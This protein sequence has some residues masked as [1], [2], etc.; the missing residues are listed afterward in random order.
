M[1]AHLT[2]VLPEY[3]KRRDALEAGL[4][5]HLPRTMRWRQPDHGVLLWLPLPFPLS[6]EAVFEEA[7]RRG[8]LVSPST[9][10]A[11]DPRAQNGVRLTFCAEPPERLAE[12]AKR[13]GKAMSQLVA[14]YAPGG[15]ITTLEVV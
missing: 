8:V 1:R 9:L 12:G 3:R 7:R 5:A 4:A 15:A 6:S 2:R 14:H 11:V 13:L 10:F